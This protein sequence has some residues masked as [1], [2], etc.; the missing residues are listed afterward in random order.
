MMESQNHLHHQE[1][2]DMETQ[3]RLTGVTVES[4]VSGN[5]PENQLPP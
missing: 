3:G 5:I 2:E 4:Q 1:E